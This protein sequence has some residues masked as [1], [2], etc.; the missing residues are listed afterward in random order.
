MTEAS[1]FVVHVLYLLMCIATQWSP[2]SDISEILLPP[3]VSSPMLTFIAHCSSLPLLQNPSTLS[4]IQRLADEGN[5]EELV[6]LLGSRMAFGTAGTYAQQHHQ[7]I[8]Y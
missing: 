7:A 1:V 4:E 2:P 5:E 3:I 8:D 6:A